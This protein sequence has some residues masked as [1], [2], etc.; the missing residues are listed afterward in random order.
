MTPTEWRE[1]SWG[2]SRASSGGW[3]FA[4]CPWVSFLH[5]KC[6]F[7]AGALACLRPSFPYFGEWPRDTLILTET[8]RVVLTAD[9]DKVDSEASEVCALAG[10]GCDDEAVG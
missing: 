8:Q 7:F 9:P 3:A 10:Q 2:K 1:P 5:T 4:Q 6:H